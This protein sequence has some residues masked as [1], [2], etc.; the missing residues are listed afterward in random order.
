MKL[1]FGKEAAAALGVSEWFVSS[2]KKAGAPFWG[3]KTDVGELEKWLQA[4]PTF[5][6]N[7]QWPRKARTTPPRGSAKL[8]LLDQRR[9]A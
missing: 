6:A 2:M 5:T 8:R 7:Q 9:P 1:V 3:Y 4:N